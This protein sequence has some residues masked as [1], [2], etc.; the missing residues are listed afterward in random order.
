M[1]MNTQTNKQTNK[2]RSTSSPPH[3]RDEYVEEEC[4]ST[5]HRECGGRRECL[6]PPR[7]GVGVPGKG[8]EGE[9]EG[10]EGGEEEGQE[11]DKGGEAEAE[12]TT[13][14]TLYT[15]VVLYR[16]RTVAENDK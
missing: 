4:C 5:R 2:H 15:E 16:G 10:G 7:W 6:P 11:E 9:G 12:K 13:D 8:E 14:T 3:L 1:S